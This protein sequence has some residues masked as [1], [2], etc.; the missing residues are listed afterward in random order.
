MLNVLLHSQIGEIACVVTR[1]YGGTKLGTGGLAR[2]YS[3]AVEEGLKRLNPIEKI[4]RTSAVIAIDYGSLN[5]FKQEC[6]QF[7]VEIRAESFCE[8]IQM[9]LAIPTEYFE[10][11]ETA[12]TNL[13]L[14]KSL[15]KKTNEN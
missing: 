4:D 9:E 10:P 8:N 11:F 2:A 3:Q 13:T 7:E 15:L 1:Y 12:V 14:G 5:R 6:C